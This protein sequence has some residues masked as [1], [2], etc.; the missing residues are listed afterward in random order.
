MARQCLRLL[1]VAIEIAERRG[2][3]Q[4]KTRGDK[5]RSKLISRR[6]GPVR[7]RPQHRHGVCGRPQSHV[8]HHQLPRLR[9]LPFAQFQL[10]HM[11]PLRFRLRSGA[12]M[13]GFPVSGGKNGILP[14]AQPLQ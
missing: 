10:A 2:V 13:H 12:G 8:P 3:L 1:G 5:V 4:R 11:H 14:I 6:A 7:R 9:P